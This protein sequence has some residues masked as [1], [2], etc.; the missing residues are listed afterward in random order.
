M[1]PSLFCISAI[2]IAFRAAVIFIFGSEFELR[3][4]PVTTS[5]ADV[6]RLCDFASL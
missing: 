4:P 6:V 1:F 3:V 5:G 2:I